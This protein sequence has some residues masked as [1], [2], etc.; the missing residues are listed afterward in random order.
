VVLSGI[1]VR[2]YRGCDS[3]L[4]RSLKLLAVTACRIQTCLTATPNSVRDVRDRPGLTSDIVCFLQVTAD[5]FSIMNVCCIDFLR[6]P[7]KNILG[8]FDLGS[9]EA[10]Y[11]TPLDQSSFFVVNVQQITLLASEVGRC[12]LMLEPHS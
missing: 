11:W 2:V 8:L 4:F 9:M 6:Q 1:W 12:T 10:R 5:V 3:I 7:H